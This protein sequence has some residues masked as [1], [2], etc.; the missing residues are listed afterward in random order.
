MHNL[1]DYIPYTGKLTS[2]SE[3]VLAWSREAGY[4]FLQAVFCLGDVR[5]IAIEEV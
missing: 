3:I 5:I 4:H 2:G 1:S